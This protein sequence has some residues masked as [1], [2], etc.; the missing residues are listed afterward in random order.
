M[1]ID[2]NQKIEINSIVNLYNFRNYSK[3]NKIKLYCDLSPDKNFKL[4]SM[5]NSIVSRFV[6]CSHLKILSQNIEGKYISPFANIN[7]ILLLKNLKQ[8]IIYNLKFFNFFDTFNINYFHNS[9]TLTEIRLQ[10]C[11]L[12]RFPEIFTYCENLE[13]LYLSDNNI[14]ELPENFK[15]LTNLKY[16]SLECNKFLEFPNEIFYFFDLKEL[17]FSH[18][19]IKII[20]AAICNLEAL[21]LL[22]LSYNKIEYISDK[23]YTCENLTY[24]DV[25][26]NPVIIFNNISNLKK[27]KKLHLVNVKKLP[28]KLSSSIEELNISFNNLNSVPK[29]IFSLKNLKILYLNNNNIKNIPE[30]IYELEDLKELILEEDELASEE[31]NN[32][33]SEFNNLNI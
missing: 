26:C 33:D 32:F 20:P 13:L 21:Q 14:F 25:S 6:N 27:L 22:D 10:N 3:F 28:N 9:N 30:E 16:L 29:M 19:Y 1:D 11:K 2:Y 12:D 8:L 4:I 7:N 15:Q 18:N 17:Y 24:L 23:L 5:F 31:I